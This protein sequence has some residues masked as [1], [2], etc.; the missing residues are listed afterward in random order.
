[1]KHQQHQLDGQLF[2]QNR[3]MLYIKPR[4]GEPTQRGDNDIINNIKNDA[5]FYYD[6]LIDKHYEDWL[7]LESNDD[8]QPPTD[9]QY[10]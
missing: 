6:T 10:Y 2:C 7:D 4:Y 1:M 8:H 5:K 3:F 9:Q